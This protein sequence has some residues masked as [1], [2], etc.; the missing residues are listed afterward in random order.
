MDRKSIQGKY[1]FCYD[2]KLMGFLK[3]AGFDYITCAIHETSGNKFWL[4]EGTSDLQISI[5]EYKKK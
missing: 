3:R 4:F 1:F 2:S 5:N